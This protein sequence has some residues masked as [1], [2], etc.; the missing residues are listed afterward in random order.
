VS[1]ALRRLALAGAL[2]GALALG[3][4]LSAGVS[5]V[6]LA[7]A[8]LGAAAVAALGLWLRRARDG[9]RRSAF[10]AT[11]RLRVVQRVGLSPRT[12]L[13]LVEVDGRPYLVVHGDGFARLRLTRRR[14]ALAPAPPR[15]EVAR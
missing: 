4:A 13:A 15:L 1:P 8:G 5:G 6:S 3:A 10:A 9:G 7:R 11:T 12:G 14:V 2:L